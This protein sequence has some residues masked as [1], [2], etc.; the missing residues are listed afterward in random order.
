MRKIGQIRG[1]VVPHKERRVLKLLLMHTREREREFVINSPS[2]PGKRAVRIRVEFAPEEL[3]EF[4]VS[5]RVVA[6][7]RSPT[8]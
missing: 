4:E 3:S 5:V 8:H 2:V 6:P 1:W 7:P